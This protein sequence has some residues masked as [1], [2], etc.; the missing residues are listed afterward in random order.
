MKQGEENQRAE[1][2]V[3]FGPVVTMEGMEEFKRGGN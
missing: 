1:W 3:V 2:E